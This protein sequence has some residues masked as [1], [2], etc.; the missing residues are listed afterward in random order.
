VEPT[1]IQDSRLY[2]VDVEPKQLQ[3][4]RPLI[5][6]PTSPGPSL[7]DLPNQPN[8]LIAEDQ[9]NTELKGDIIIVHM[10]GKANLDNSLVGLTQ[11]EQEDL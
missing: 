5:T 2:D 6:P 11:E 7:P 3:D 10:P 1:Q 8:Q 4:S 9:Q